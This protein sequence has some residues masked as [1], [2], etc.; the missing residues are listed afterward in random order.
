MQRFALNR[1]RQGYSGTSCLGGFQS[2]HTG[3]ESAMT[4]LLTKEL[5]SRLIAS[6][7]SHSPFFPLKRNNRTTVLGLGTGWG[8]KVIRDIWQ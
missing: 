3:S 7:V 6:S 5:L 2:E 1:I 8:G 4:H